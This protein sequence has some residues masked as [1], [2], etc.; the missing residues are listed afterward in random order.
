MSDEA[1][2]I[3]NLIPPDEVADIESKAK[4]IVQGHE[5]FYEMSVM[6]SQEDMLEAVRAGYGMRIGDEQSWMMGISVLMSLLGTMEM[7]LKKDKI[8]IWED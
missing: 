7:A 5:T 8:N 1:E 2:W 6:M 4:R 3:K